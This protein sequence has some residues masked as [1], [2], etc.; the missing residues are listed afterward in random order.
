MLDTFAFA[1]A[2]PAPYIVLGLAGLFAFK[3]TVVR[4]GRAS[5]EGSLG[6]VAGSVVL[7]GIAFESW[8]LV[9]HVLLGELRPTAAD[10][11]AAGGEATGV[12]EALVAVLERFPPY[13]LA[14]AVFLLTLMVALLCPAAGLRNGAP[15]AGEPSRPGSRWT[16]CASS[17]RS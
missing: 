8:A 13:S 11:G 5:S 4:M 17:R 9:A 14:A 10:P 2:A 7:A 15:S 6:T 16:T 12:V 3:A 1:S